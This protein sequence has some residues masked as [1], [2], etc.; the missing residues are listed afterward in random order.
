MLYGCLAGQK[1]F[2]LDDDIRDLSAEQLWR[3][4]DLLDKH[5][6]VG[7][8]A[9]E[10]PDNSVVC[11]ANRL[12]GNSQDIFITGGSL[13]VNPVAARSFFPHVYNEDWLFCYDTVRARD[14][15][16]LGSVRQLAYDPFNPERAKSEE[17]GDVLAEGLH[18]LL[19]LGAL[20]EAA[21]EQFW[22]YYLWR[23]RAFIADIA[24]RL[25]A[26]PDTG[27]NRAVQALMA[28]GA[29]K[30]KLATFA[31]SDFVTYVNDWR[32][33][34][35]TWSSTLESLPQS[36]PAKEAARLLAFITG[37]EVEFIGR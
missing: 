26:L 18:Y 3:V 2:F 25:A 32:H 10:H 34:V 21:D 6:I 11:H 28:L 31:P 8:L 9:D 30:D 29:S 22:R 23:R 5:A 4:G 27:D 20:F 13:G 7:F 17:F 24:K 37:L 36:K 14:A 19:A 16:F 35:D 33:D 12:A 1:I 15:A